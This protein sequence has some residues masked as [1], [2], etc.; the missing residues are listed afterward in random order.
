MLVVMAETTIPSPT[1]N[2]P[3]KNRLFLRP[4]YLKHKWLDYDKTQNC[5]A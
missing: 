1:Q 4:V 2:P 5:T 3:A